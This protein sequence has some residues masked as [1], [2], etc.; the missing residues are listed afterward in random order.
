[1]WGP[2]R[3]ASADLMADRVSA[4]RAA[5]EDSVLRRT[6]RGERVPGGTGAAVIWQIYLC[7]FPRKPAIT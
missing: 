5:M 6:A 2:M 4:H 7:T 1:M 3:P